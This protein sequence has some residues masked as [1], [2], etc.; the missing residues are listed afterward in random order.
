MMLLHAHHKNLASYVS[1]AWRLYQ[2]TSVVTKC[3]WSYILPILEYCSPVWNSAADTHMR[4]LD[5]IV[6]SVTALSSGKV[7]CDLEHRRSV[8]ELCVFHKLF[9]NADHPVNRHMPGPML[10]RRVTRRTEAAH[11]FSVQPITCRTEQF[12]RCF[13][14]R[15]AML[16]NSLEGDVFEGSTL[17][18]FK[19]RTNRLLLQ[20][21]T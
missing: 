8:A 16:W 3:F 12:S 10:R 18:S 1:Q 21:Q 5:R 13:I 9:F 11:D 19:S 14:P 2:D 6:R 20:R 17:S 15:V 4:L 7:L